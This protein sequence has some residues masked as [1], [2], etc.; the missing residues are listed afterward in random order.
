MVVS[1]A[2]YG[3]PPAALASSPPGAKQVSPLV[4]GAEAIEE[5]ADLSLKRAVILAPAGTI[6]RRYVVAQALRALEPGGVLV[7]LAPK[8]KGGMRLRG[9][10]EAF[11]CVVNETARRHH[12]IV[13][14]AAPQA[15]AGVPDAIAAGGPQIPPGLGLWSQPGVFSWDRLDPGTGLLLEALPPLSGRGADLGG[16][17]GIL[18]KAVLGSANVSSLLL[19][20]IDARAI[21]AARRNI[22]DE[23]AMFEHRDV[24]DRAPADLDFVVM[25]PPFHDAGREDRA[26]GQAFISAAAA[27]LRPGGACWMVANVALPYEAV[28]AACF[29]RVTSVTQARGYKV[30]EAR[31]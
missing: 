15:P 17:I 3:S 7:A 30:Y 27:S 13:T 29:S 24:R 18:S 26:L 16:G 6:E 22:V 31:K 14:C 25:N 23:R 2:V 11:G 4:P 9:E 21:A 1:E 12:R 19:L 10:L 5:I 8:G 20:D 28:L